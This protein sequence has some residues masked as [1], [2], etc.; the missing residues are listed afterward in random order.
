MSKQAEALLHRELSQVIIGSFYEVYNQLGYGFLEQVYETAL[1]HELTKRGL[2]VE[3]Q[4]AIRVYYDGR[5]VGEFFADLLVENCIIVELKAAESIH[6]RYE[7]QLLNYLK[8]TDVEVGLLLNFGPEARFKR[9]VFTNV[10]K[11]RPSKIKKN[12]RQST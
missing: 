2:N 10:R 6:A 9:K 4:A 1:A 7:A 8:A 11:K 3:R 12:P 5:V